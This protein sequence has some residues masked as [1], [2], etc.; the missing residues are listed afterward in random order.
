[1][2]SH[3]ARWKKATSVE[4]L[5]FGFFVLWIMQGMQWRLNCYAC[6]P[7]IN[8]GKQPGSVRQRMLDAQL[9]CLCLCSKR[10]KATSVR[11]RRMLEARSP[12]TRLSS[13]GGLR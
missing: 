5:M 13:G 3:D 4:R 12:L 2:N 7:R 6:A 8:G 10:R 1:M 9:L 11:Q